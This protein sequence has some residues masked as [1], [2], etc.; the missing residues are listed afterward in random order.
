MPRFKK[1]KN[2]RKFG[3]LLVGNLML[4]YAVMAQRPDL[5]GSLIVDLGVNSWSSAPTD[6]K[7]NGFQSKTVNIIYYYDLAIGNRGLTFTP[8]IG[9]GLEKYSFEDD[10]TLTSTVNNSNVRS[11]AVSNLSAVFPQANSFDK[12]KLGLN[13]LDV[14]LEFRYY[15][16]KD[17]LSRGFRVALGAKVGVLYSSF[18]KAKFEDNAADRRMVKD[19]QDLGFNR[20]RYGIQGR[21]GV[22]GFS[23][24]G[25]YEL[26]DKFD[27][28]PAGGLDTK[29]LTLGISL[30]GF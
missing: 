23:I 30:T 22:G 21:I 16:S 18:T 4:C 15:T 11:I 20:F 26:S 29:T 25:Y 10:K 6:L 17:N 27:R 3:L 1:E 8:G 24:F 5:P 28:A 13:Y 12:S 19:R 14:P 7:L 2:M 9:L